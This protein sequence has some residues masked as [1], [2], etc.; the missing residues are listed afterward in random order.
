MASAPIDENP[1]EPSKNGQAAGG[2]VAGGQT[3]GGQAS[4]DQ[5]PGGPGVGGQEPGGQEAGTAAD[6]KPTSWQARCL[7]RA[8]RAGTLAT[9]AKGQP[10]ASL[11]TPACMPDGSLL[12]LL[13][14]LAEHT[15]HLLADPR[16]SVLV[17]GAPV[18][19]NPQTTPR[20]TVTGVAEVVDDKA[21][22][23]RYLAVHPYAT[24]YADFG[25]FSTWRIVPAAGILVGGFARAF[26][27]KAADFAPDPAAAAAIL[28]AEKVIIAHCNQDHPDA[29]AAIARQAI[30][31]KA[32][33]GPMGDWRMVTVDVDGFDLALG[34]LVVRQ[35][36]SAPVSDA[37]DVRRELVRLAQQARGG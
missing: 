2:Q 17:S 29:L 9:S 32:G 22:K 15:R 5:K 28:A 33:A 16:C 31:R 25:D 21:L 4:G 8:A 24:L 7:L 11:V 27:L 12:L 13:S 30:A 20:V 35:A 18:S 36:W 3:S 6:G 14:R 34:E 37:M 19:E 23:S 1:A 26:R 10:Y